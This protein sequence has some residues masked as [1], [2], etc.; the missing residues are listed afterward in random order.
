MSLARTAI[1]LS[2]LTMAAAAGVRFWLDRAAEAALQADLA[3]V[4]VVAEA[5]VRH[6]CGTTGP[7]SP[8]SLL[9]AAQRLGED[10]P[11]VAA[12]DRWSLQWTARPGGAGA[13]VRIRYRLGSEE[14][15]RALFASLPGAT[16][17]GGTI[18]IPVPRRLDG[19]RSGFRWLMSDVPC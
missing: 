12:P 4:R 8:E 1:V 2:L 14:V 5:Y 17:S 7:T 10:P 6:F 15:G 3:A 18:E 19:N 11:G 9:Q 16:E 13:V